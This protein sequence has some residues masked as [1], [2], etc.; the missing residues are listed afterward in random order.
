MSVC[1][2]FIHLLNTGDAND[3]SAVD[4]D[5]EGEGGDAAAAAAATGAAEEAGAEAGAPKKKKKKKKKKGG[6]GGGV[7]TCPGGT[8]SKVAP[9][10]GVTGFTD[11]YV[12]C[13]DRRGLFS[14][15]FDVIINIR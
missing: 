10:R 2:F 14:S 9:A 4:G 6:G 13:G 15:V 5:E 11:S 7:P 3:A 12:R 1:L 8:G